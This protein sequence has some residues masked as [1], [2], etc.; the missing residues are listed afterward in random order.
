[1]TPLKRLLFERQIQLRKL[2]Q[3]TG[4]TETS[5][6]LI[7]NGKRLPNLVN[8]FRIAKALDVSLEDLWGYIMEEGEL[9]KGP[10]E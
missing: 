10:H 9:E 6:S 4:M 1:M 8:A 7:V 2:A 5:L 3:L